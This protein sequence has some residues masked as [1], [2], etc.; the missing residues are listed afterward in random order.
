MQSAFPRYLAL[1]FLSLILIPSAEA[2]VF[3]RVSDVD[4]VD[5][6]DLI[7]GGV[8]RD[9]DPGAVGEGPVTSYLV[10]V[11]RVLKGQVSGS[12]LSVRV[13]GGVD[14]S[15]GM[16][17]FVYGMP[18]WRTGE[19]ALLFLNRDAGG[20]PR[21]QHAFQGAFHVAS[22]DGRDVAFRNFGEA[23][24]AELPGR[25][26]TLPAEGPRDLDSFTRWIEA[27][28]S[29]DA[30]EE[31]Y[32]LDVSISELGL[33]SRFNLLASGGR[34]MRWRNFDS[35]G[36]VSWRAHQQGQPGLSG[37]GFNQFQTALQSWNNDPSTPIRL[38]YAGTTNATAGFSSFDGVNAIV[39]NDLNNASAGGFDEPFSCFSGGTIAIG[40]PWFSTSTTHAFN[41]QTYITIQGGDIVTNTGLECYIAT[42]RR[43]DEVFAHELG[44]TLGLAH[45]CGD[46]ET[47]PCNTTAKNE[48]LMRASAHGDG[49]GASL[50]DDDRAAITFLYGTPLTTPTAPSGLSASNGGTGVVNLGWNDN[51]SNE[52]SFRIERQ[53]NGGSF[54]QIASV[55]SG[56]ESYTDNTVASG[57]PYSYR[58]R[59]SNAAG[60]S[61]F[62]NVASVTTSGESPP[63]GLSATPQSST[64][65]RLNWTDNGAGETGFEIEAST[66]GAF[67]VVGTA[68][69]GA[70]SFN[71]T[72]LVPATEYTFRVRSIGGAGTSTYSNLAAATTFAGE[73]SDCE[74]DGDTLCLQN[75]RFKVEIQW[76]DFTGAVDAANVVPGG[77]DDSGLFWFFEADN[78]EML[79]KVLDGCGVNNRFWVFA[80]ATTNVEY[81][82]VVTDTDTGAVSQYFNPL[83]TAAPAI[84]DT[85]AFATCPG[86]TSVGEVP[87]PGGAATAT[88]S[89]LRFTPELLSSSPSGTTA[90]GGLVPRVDCTATPTNMCLNNGRFKVEVD[91]RDFSGVRDSGQVVPLGSDDS[92][93]FWFFE[94][95]NWEMLVKVLDGCGVNER[96]W[97]FAAATTNVEY[98]LTVT[99]TD[100]GS[101]RE[102]F[103][104]LGTAAPAITDI[105]VFSTCP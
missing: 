35:G 66:F 86:G 92:G 6:A 45:S 58:V 56:S 60:N 23:E 16:E 39:F 89:R 71:A 69:A 81:T 62:S 21:I 40:G 94:A 19:R 78:W 82:L 65:V 25:A 88:Q 67:S 51:S 17:L 9:I 34:N 8:V 7:V 53:A 30:A 64:V 41:G 59:A 100:N 33:Q 36:S 48:A 12:V 43:A 2:T 10:E 46:D 5:Q 83:G 11:E 98:T 79:V 80:A 73:P 49:R 50:R 72:G 102:F 95:D 28:V 3:V 24:E 75:G 96:Y 68:A 57:T 101:V 14:A 1:F 70:T 85:D 26:Q 93:L 90:D 38:T 47:G 74:A 103:N 13:P 42:N 77:S 84:T 27:R 63:T 15:T 54:Q 37:G 4:L 20:E 31:N 18:R 105:D 104:P 61:S 91:F 99:D 52:T 76:R 87:E 55:G 22:H 44:H 32:R 29:G 97:V